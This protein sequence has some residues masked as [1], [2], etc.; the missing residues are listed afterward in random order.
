[1][2]KFHTLSTFVVATLLLS[3]TSCKQ[4]EEPK[5]EL[6]EV[7]P[8]ISLDNMDTNVDPKQDFY[9]Y[10]NG[11][12]LKNNTIPEDEVSWGGFSVLR[13][14][15]RKDLLEIV[16]FA[17]ESSAY[18]AGSDQ[19]KALLLFDSEMDTLT[20]DSLGVGPILPS[21]KKIDEVE[22]MEEL[23]HLM[24]TD[25]A[26]SAPFVG[27]GVSADLNNSTMNTMYI[28][29]GRLGLPDR[30][31]YLNQDEKSKQIREQYKDFMV[32]MFDY[33]G[34]DSD[35]A[36]KNAEIVL[37]LETK[38][39][40]PRMDKVERRDARKRNNPRTLAELQ[41]MS[42]VFGWEKMF[43][44]SGIEKEVDSV[45]VSELKYMDELN[46]IIK[47]TPFEDLKTVVKWSTLR[48]AA[49]SLSTDIERTS[50]D[51]YSK[52]LRGAK[53]QQPLNERALGTVTGSVGEALGKLYVEAKFPPEAKQKAELMIGNVI[54]AFQNRIQVLDWMSEETKTKAIEKLENLTVK[55]GYP[56]EWE[57]YSKLEIKEGNSLAENM[58]AVRK[59]RTEKNY[60]ELYEPVDKGRWG[61]APQTVNAYFNPRNN[62]IVF[63]AAILQPPFYNYQ[64]DEA[65]N[66]GGMGAVIG[67][68]ISHAFDDSGSRYDKDGNLKNWWTDGDLEEFTKRGNALADQY[69]KIEVLDSVFI[70]GKFTL[71]EN[72]GDLGG[73]LG[74][75][76]G[77]QLYFQENGRPENID[78]FTPEQRFF[79]SWATVWR[80]LMRDDALRNQILTDPHS[81]G[82]Y[83]AIQP[84]KNIDAFYSAFEIK[85]G[86]GMYLAPEERVRIW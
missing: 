34:V 19:K 65:V 74:A 79:M 44:D 41:S 72:I 85:E 82:M 67:H 56:D 18:A 53:A 21:L 83:R 11:S 61:M 75:Y 14:S 6:A 29:P 8:G 51:F 43:K 63:P 60:S 27:Y 30:D 58:E 70:N 36:K 73:L 10:V 16:S 81:P 15:T 86:D 1:M 32:N 9:N 35:Q 26:V 22:N 47:N 62:E 42:P 57:D 38:L 39:A 48:G 40:E 23:Q 50:W 3:A 68:E 45:I 20:R 33:V 5:E 52:T 31:Y 17:K 2:T 80:T 55:I 78:G 66:Y 4:K 46:K 59:F 49:G 28:S 13:K 77:L 64:A 76:D 12:W 37:A 7:I 69:S 84:L 24:A 71:G 54:K 25:Y